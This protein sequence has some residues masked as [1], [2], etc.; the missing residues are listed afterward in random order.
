MIRITV[1]NENV[2]ENGLKYA[3]L[4]PADPASRGRAEWLETN[5][6]NVLAVHPEGIH[7]TLRALFEEETDLR[8]RTATLDMPECGLS[9]GTLKDTD[10]LVWWAHCAHDRVPDAI[11][12]RVRDH[13]L[14]GMGL[15]VLHSAHL[16]KPFR[17]LMGTSGTLGWREG[18]RSRVWCCCP[19]HPI[20]AGIPQSFDLPEE[21]MYQEYFDIPRPDD[22]VF[23]S[24]FA[25]GEVFR[26][27]CTWTRGRGRVFYFQPGHETQRSYF[28][29]EVRAIL[30]NAARWAAP[31]VRLEELSCP[32]VVPSAE[33][34][35]REGAG[36]N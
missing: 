36:R 14:R 9:E 34:R 25:G 33:E 4:D 13:V 7:N 1:W 3:E 19:T 22:I 30:K 2:Q 27:G 28:V 26:S 8:V 17:L 15:I 11:A 18:D 5:Q 6:K 29:P 35:Y 16:S 32:H 31:A 24:W 10:V 23:I 21:E 12:E 20:A